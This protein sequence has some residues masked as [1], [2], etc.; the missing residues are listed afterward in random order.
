MMEK[1]CVPPLSSHA[2]YKNQQKY[3]KIVNHNYGPLQKIH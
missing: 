2:N 3:V 1:L